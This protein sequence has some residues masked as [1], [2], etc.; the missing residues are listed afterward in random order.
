MAKSVGLLW[1]IVLAVV[2]V[3]IVVTITI[4]AIPV[5]AQPVGCGLEGP[6][7]CTPRLTVEWLPSL[8][9]GVVAASVVVGVLIGLWGLVRRLSIEESSK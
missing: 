1:P 4:W 3:A 2:W 5:F 6:P 7:T 8:T 9:M